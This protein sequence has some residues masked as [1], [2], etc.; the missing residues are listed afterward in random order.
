MAHREGKQ[1]NFST[2]VDF[3]LL[4]QGIFFITLTHL[5]A[6]KSIRF[7]GNF[8][9]RFLKNKILFSFYSV[10]VLHRF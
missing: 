2:I 6:D 5:I 4:K 7:I 10:K 8:I 1:L 3:S 9:L